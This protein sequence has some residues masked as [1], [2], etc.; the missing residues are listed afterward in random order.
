MGIRLR[1][2]ADDVRRIPAESGYRPVEYWSCHRG[3]RRAVRCVRA[4][5]IS[6]GPPR[7]A[8]KGVENATYQR[9]RGPTPPAAR[10]RA[11]RHSTPADLAHGELVPASRTAQELH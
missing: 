2:D 5:S 8:A 10:D 4:R 1:H 9:Q 6:L 3:P 7:I 11:A